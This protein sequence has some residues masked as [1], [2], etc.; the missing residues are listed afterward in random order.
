[1]KR[2]KALP[3]IIATGLCLTLGYSPAMAQ[4][5]VEKYDM[6]NGST[7]VADWQEGYF[8]VTG[9]ATS[10]YDTNRIKMKLMSLE[11]ARVMA[12]FRLVELI[13]G[14]QITAGTKVV[15]ASFSGQ[16]VAN[17]VKGALKG[18]VT[19]KE[20]ITWSPSGTGGS[21]EV[22]EAAVT[23]RICFR[24][25]APACVKH[26]GG[27]QGVYRKLQIDKV[28]LPPIE[29]FKPTVEEVAKAEEVLQEALK[30]APVAIKVYTA[31]IVSMDGEPYQPSLAPEIVTNNGELVYAISQ[32][33]PKA[34]FR[35]GPVQFANTIEDA[36]AIKL[37][38]DNPLQMTAEL[39]NSDGQIV[40][41]DENA[42]LVSAASAAG[43][44]FLKAAK[45]TI[46]LE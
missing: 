26:G 2:I 5:L 42:S 16:V 14:V 9:R 28:E 36:R 46:V 33:S 3:A 41:S 22:P 7:G 25:K 6:G 30:E 38:G 37:M 40:L 15:D 21:T 10:K 13:E 18:A 8:E 12:Q 24:D 43:D 35:S 29:E 39:L 45:V 44:N 27:Q 34:L 1:M 11:A 31:L 4:Q 17:R 32:I 19:I 20:E 23:L